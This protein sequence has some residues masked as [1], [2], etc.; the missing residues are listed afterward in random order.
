MSVRVDVVILGNDYCA[1]FRRKGQPDEFLVDSA[2]R[3]QKFATASLAL[4]QGRKA[5]AAVKAPPI[6]PELPDLLGAKVW[7]AQKDAEIAAERQRVFGPS[8]PSVLDVGGKTVVVERK[9]RRW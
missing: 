3:P 4:R 6:A 7:R 1:V 5:A 8:R 9:R 2:G